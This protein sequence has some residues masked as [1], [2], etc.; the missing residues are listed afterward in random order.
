[1]KLR[2]DGQQVHFKIDRSELTRLCLGASLNHCIH[3]PNGRG[4]TVSVMTGRAAPPMQLIFDNDIM[5]LVVDRE[6]AYDLLKGLPRREGIAAH[7]PVH[8]NDPM[9]L[10]LDVDSHARDHSRDRT[11]DWT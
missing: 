11:H 4:L 7:Q 9:E 6:A 3:F 2:I 8:P 10:I 5:Q 1:M